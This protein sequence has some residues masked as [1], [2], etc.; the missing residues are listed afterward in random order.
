VTSD[1]CCEPAEFVAVLHALD[2]PGSILRRAVES[3]RIGRISVRIVRNVRKVR[4]LAPATVE[5]LR[6]PTRQR[7]AVLICDRA[8]WCAAV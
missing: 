1:S 8:A 5:A 3:E 6:A 7:E 4:P 2:L